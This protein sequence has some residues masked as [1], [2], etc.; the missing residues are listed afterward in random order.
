MT[1]KY[2]ARNDDGP[3]QIAELATRLNRLETISHTSPD[4]AGVV[5]ESEYNTP[6]VTVTSGTFSNLFRIHGGAARIGVLAHLRVVTPGGTTMEVQL[7]DAD[8]LSLISPV[9]TVPASTTDHIHLGGRR[10]DLQPFRDTIIQAR[11]ASGAGTSRIGVLLAAQG[12]YRAE[13]S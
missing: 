12:D 10:T 6:A 1:S 8:D 13:V 4:I 11:L 7:L 3:T 9:A 2:H 5:T